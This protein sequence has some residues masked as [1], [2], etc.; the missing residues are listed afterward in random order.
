MQVKRQKKVLNSTPEKKIIS[1]VAQEEAMQCSG[2]VRGERGLAQP[3][4]QQICGL[5]HQWAI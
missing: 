5:L 2:Y 3:A 4:Q 1:K